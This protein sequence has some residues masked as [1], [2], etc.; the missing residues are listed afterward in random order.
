MAALTS[1]RQSNC[2]HRRSLCDAAQTLSRRRAQPQSPSVHR[3]VIMKTDSQLQ[4][5]VI[6]ELNWEPSV[7]AA[8]IGVEVQGGVVTLAGHVDSYAEK[9]DAER[10]AQRVSGVMALAIEIDVKLPGDSQRID[11]DIARSA[12]NVLQWMAN[13]ARD[14]V[15]VVVEQGRITLSG[16]VAWDY[17]R[18]AAAD[19]VRYLMGVTGVTNHIAIKPAV[20]LNAVQADIEAA[21]KRRA[22][23]DAQS[24]QVEVHGHDVTLTGN[25]HS[26]AERE[27]ARHS[28]WGTPGVHSVIDKITVRY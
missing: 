21:L 6:A 12:Q 23:K 15:K 16:E 7:N 13:L 22:A 2:C 18:R 1:L 25:V 4:Q 14:S 3:I 9:C 19:A 20:S 28:A 11:A 17:Q 26:W 8:Q 24:I 10:A 5:D 27:L